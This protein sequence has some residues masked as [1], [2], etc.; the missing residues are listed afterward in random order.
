MTDLPTTLRDIAS[1]PVF[2][3]RE[4][5]ISD[6]A[7]VEAQR[8]KGPLARDSLGIV[9]CFRQADLF[10]VLDDTVSRQIETESLALRGITKGV[11]HLETLY[12][13]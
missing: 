11:N 8:Q 12:G 2:T 4:G 6:L 10:Q 3:R 1:I 13:T 5:G 7:H 9:H